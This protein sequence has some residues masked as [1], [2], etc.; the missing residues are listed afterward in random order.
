LTVSIIL[1][2]ELFTLFFSRYYW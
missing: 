1:K 2:T